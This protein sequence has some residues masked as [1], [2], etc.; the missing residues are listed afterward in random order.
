[1]LILILIVWLKKERGMKTQSW[2]YILTTYVKL[3]G[4]IEVNWANWFKNVLSICVNHWPL[5]VMDS[6]IL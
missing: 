1:M 3:F 5:F 6:F 4:K 2:Q